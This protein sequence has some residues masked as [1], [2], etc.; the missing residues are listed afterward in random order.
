MEHNFVFPCYW[1]G[2]ACQL[3]AP[4]YLQSSNWEELKQEVMNISPTSNKGAGIL[5]L[6]VEILSMIAS[7]TN[8]PIWHTLFALSHPDI[9]AAV[10]VPTVLPPQRPGAEGL[11]NAN[12]LKLY[13]NLEKTF[14]PDF[15]YCHECKILHRVGHLGLAGAGSNPKDRI[16]IGGRFSQL[17]YQYLNL[18]G[19]QNAICPGL[20]RCCER[21]SNLKLTAFTPAQEPGTEFILDPQKTHAKANKEQTRSIESAGG[22]T[23]AA[24]SGRLPLRHRMVKRLVSALPARISLI[25]PYKSHGKSEPRPKMFESSISFNIEYNIVPYRIPTG[26]LVL[27]SAVQLVFPLPIH[28]NAPVGVVFDPDDFRAK[29]GTAVR[30]LDWRICQH[31]S[32][33]WGT[34]GA[35][36][37]SQADMVFRG[38]DA[39]INYGPTVVACPCCEIV[40]RIKLWDPD[41]S[42]SYPYG[43]VTITTRQQVGLVQQA[44][45]KLEDHV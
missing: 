25:R 5:S 19:Y 22:S 43:E 38:Y 18:V 7:E 27:H 20:L 1:G 26:G 34:L 12:R 9:Y 3:H 11:F 17:P 44:I 30:E 32:T 21:D 35:G 41:H 39:P 10:G 6:P 13:Q 33:K 31:L 42:S 4:P 37:K 24:S 2:H 29:I 15:R 8:S 23:P 14:W 45:T 16:D 28:G 40:A 36:L